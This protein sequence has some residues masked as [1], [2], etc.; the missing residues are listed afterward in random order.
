MKPPFFFYA[1][2][3]NNVSFLF[4]PHLSSTDSMIVASWLWFEMGF[5]NTSFASAVIKGEAFFRGRDG[6][7]AFR[8]WF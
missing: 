2:V 5:V 4:L 3:N 6:K 7:I 1:A 8:R